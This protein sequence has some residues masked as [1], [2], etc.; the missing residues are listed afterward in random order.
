M[1]SFNYAAKMKDLPTLFEKRKL[2]EYDAS[3]AGEVNACVNAMLKDLQTLNVK[4]FSFVATQDAHSDESIKDDDFTTQFNYENNDTYQKLTKITKFPMGSPTVKEKYIH[5]PERIHSE[6][7]S[8]SWDDSIDAFAL[9]RHDFETEVETM[10]NSFPMIYAVEKDNLSKIGLNQLGYQGLSFPA[11][12]ETTVTNRGDSEIPAA[13][14]TFYMD[15]FFQF[16]KFMKE[17]DTRMISMRLGTATGIGFP[18]NGLETGMNALANFMCIR[19]GL[20]FIQD[21]RFYKETVSEWEAATD[22]PY[23]AARFGRRLQ[24]KGK[25]KTVGVVTFDAASPDWYIKGMEPA[26]RPINIVNKA[27][28]VSVKGI[29]KAVLKMYQLFPFFITERTKIRVILNKWRAMKYKIYSSDFKAMGTSIR[30]T[31]R[32]GYVKCHITGNVPEWIAHAAMYPPLLIPS[33]GDDHQAIL[34]NTFENNMPTGAENTSCENCFTHLI[35]LLWWYYDMFG[36]MNGAWVWFERNCP[37]LIWGDDGITAMKDESLLIKL[38]DF[39]VKLGFVPSVSEEEI[40]LMTQYHDGRMTNIM[41]RAINSI[42]NPERP[43]PNALIRT[44]KIAALTELLTEHPLYE[45]WNK[46]IMSYIPKH[47]KTQPDAVM[48]LADSPSACLEFVKSEEC[49]KMLREYAAG[50]VANRKQ[51]EQVSMSLASGSS[52]ETLSGNELIKQILIPEVGDLEYDVDISRDFLTDAQVAVAH[53]A[54]TEVA[55]VG[56]DAPGALILDEMAK[57]FDLYVTDEMAKKRSKIF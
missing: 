36:T 32:R 3:N 41:W 38:T 49:K 15:N 5:R 28:G 10:K 46:N 22:V 27:V 56:W 18:S 2:R 30:G 20:R 43:V 24:S 47:D 21:E 16:K 57:R 9:C 6:D 39:K 33:R 26:Q 37:F 48:Y 14:L 4:G 8:A 19:I 1:P 40:F 53:K 7:I 35:I 13:V 50:S 44:V 42:F 34:T 55:L 54:Y 51:I 52:P 23:N 17:S 45:W 31:F 25:Y 29:A 12:R 11:N